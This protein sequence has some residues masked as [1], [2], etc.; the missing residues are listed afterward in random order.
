MFSGRYHTGA[1]EVYLGRFADCMQKSTI[2]LRKGLK[3]PFL[4]D[5]LK[6]LWHDSDEA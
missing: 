4:S 3:N 6:K 5:I 1:A 2:F